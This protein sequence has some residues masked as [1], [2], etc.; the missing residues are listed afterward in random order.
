V[1]V[2]TLRGCDDPVPIPVVLESISRC[3]LL[4]SMVWPY[5]GSHESLWTP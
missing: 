3:R 2:S 4:L 5:L 1:C